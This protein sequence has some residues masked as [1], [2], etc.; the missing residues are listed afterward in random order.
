MG[1]LRSIL[2]PAPDE[3][4]SVRRALDTKATSEPVVRE[5]R[6]LLSQPVP[7]WASKIDAH[8]EISVEA[9]DELELAV[10]ERLA[11]LRSYRSGERRDRAIERHQA[12]AEQIALWRDELGGIPTGQSAESDSV[13]SAAA[14]RA[15]SAI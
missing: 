2:T 15:L 12:A 9:L 11:V 3:V 5:Q 1:I 14:D 10:T 4:D 8:T 13:D 6:S 7:T